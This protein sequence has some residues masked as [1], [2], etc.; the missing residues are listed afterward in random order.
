MTDDPI[1]AALQ[2]LAD[3]HDQLT[4]LTDLV[5]AIGDT[6]REHQAALEKLADTPPADADPDGYRPFPSPAWW[7]LAAADRA[8]PLTRLQAWVEQVYRPGYGHLAATL[9]PCW[10]SHDLC[11][12]G[13][14]IASDL[15]SVL[16]LQPERTPRTLS[17]QAE[18]Q[19]RI[20]PALYRFRT[21]AVVVSWY[22][23][24]ELVP[25]GS[26]LVS[27]RLLY[28]IVVRVFGWLVLLGRSQA[29]KNAEIIVLRHEVAVLRRQVT[30]P[31][32]DWA[33]RAILAALAQLL[34]S[35]LRARRLVTPGT[36]L[37]WH[38]RLITRKWTYPNRPGRPRTRP[39]IRDLVLRLAHE[40][41]AWGY[42]RVHG[43]LCRLGHRISAATVRRILRARRWRPAPR[44]MD[45]SWRAF[46]RTQAEGLLA[47]DFFHVDTIFLRRLYVLFVM[48]VGTRH[49]HVLGVA[50]HPD[51]S[52]T[53]QQARNLLIDLGG[54]IGSFRFLIRDR[55]AKFTSVFDE[56]FASEGVTVVKT[57]PQ[58]PRA[59]CYAERWIRSVR[60]ECTDRML[61]YGERHLLSVL[62]EYAGHYNRHRPH[63][64]RQQRPPDHSGLADVPLDLPVQRRK[65]LGGV[66]NEYYQAA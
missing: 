23:P 42:R 24:D 35:V 54:R 17:A 4:Q 44:R 32:P 47:C 8:E 10:S 26:R 27:L 30:R 25:A 11:L 60:A 63:Q 56:I 66:I 16:Y 40:N 1:T 37:A 59:N 58:T 46:L 9:A 64:S 5:T 6:L 62:D 57:P 43:E 53:A 41:P 13:L 36:L 21:R 45:T 34:P 61:I 22:L 33:D 65:V 39:D 3:H 38:R 29:S 18:Y 51:G 48:E 28:L 20:L 2:Q 12:Y 15:W 19:A 31:E 49:V 7:K 52:W 14:D 50:A 55:D